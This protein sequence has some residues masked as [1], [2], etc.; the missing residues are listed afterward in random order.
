MPNVITSHRLIVDYGA[1]SR[2]DDTLLTVYFSI[3]IVN[4]PPVKSRRARRDDTVLI[5]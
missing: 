2:S 4:H 3:R 5:G 1:K